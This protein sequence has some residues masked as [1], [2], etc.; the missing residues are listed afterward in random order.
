[1]P[2]SGS[3]EKWAA[4]LLVMTLGPG[5]GCK[6]SAQGMVPVIAPEHVP[7][8]GRIT[9]LDYYESKT[10]VAATYWPE[11]D[12]RG[13]VPVRVISV[14]DRRTKWNVGDAQAKAVSDRI[15]HL[16]T[17][18]SR[19][20][21][22]RL[23]EVYAQAAAGRFKLFK[24]VLSGESYGISIFAKQ[25]KIAARLWF[26][27]M[28]MLSRTFATAVDP[29]RHV[30]VGACSCGLPDTITEFVRLFPLVNT[31]TG[32]AG[33]S[34][35]GGMA[36]Q[37]IT[38]WDELTDKPGLKTLFPVANRKDYGEYQGDGL[39]K[40]GTWSRD[41]KGYRGY[42]MPLERLLRYVRSI[43]REEFAATMEGRCETPK[44]SNSGR[45]VDYYRY[46]TELVL[47]EDYKA[48]EFEE[49]RKKYTRHRSQA[50]RLRHWPEVRTKF[51]AKHGPLV[52]EGFAHAQLPPPDLAAMTRA[53]LLTSIAKL[54]ASPART[55]PLAT[56]VDGA[57]G[58]LHA[59]RDLDE[60]L[61]PESWL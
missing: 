3:L 58:L 23:A 60:A 56:R 59:L 29:V 45:I 5:T 22:F 17:P 50:M 57:L 49:D 1:M 38:D 15:N 48:P 27:D 14:A 20:M 2:A 11:V 37:D 52:L 8:R 44:D 10:A 39:I 13:E 30:F 36:V 18:R 21:F 19:L 40:M 12:A 55:G 61:I 25:T 34:P 51:F 4:V 24:V 47:R 53:S 43:E 28:A 7:L 9:Q 42:L 35:I 32:Y 54:E 26:D 6:G 31:V 16:T 46:L 41:R 33:K